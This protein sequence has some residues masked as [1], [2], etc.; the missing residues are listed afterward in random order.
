MYHLSVRF[1]Y[2]NWWYSIHKMFNITLQCKLLCKNNV[3]NRVIA[4][5][6]TV[7]KIKSVVSVLFRLISESLSN[8]KQ[9]G[10]RNF[11]TSES[12][13]KLASLSPCVGLVLHYL[14]DRRNLINSIAIFLHISL[15][16]FHFQYI[17]V[18]FSIYFTFVVIITKKLMQVDKKVVYS[19]Y[20]IISTTMQFVERNFVMRKCH[21]KQLLTILLIFLS[22]AGI[23]YLKFKLP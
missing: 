19:I 1:I 6:L 13:Q 5:R 18:H 8:G 7:A 2:K 22:A 3:K 14:K 20:A 17:L 11:W 4:S 9:W 23:C 12:M 21:Y 15:H 10:Y 16:T